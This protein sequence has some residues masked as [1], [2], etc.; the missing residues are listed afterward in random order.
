LRGL[1]VSAYRARFGVDRAWLEARTARQRELGNL[2]FLDDGAR[3]RVVPSRWLWH[4]TIATG[5]L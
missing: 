3:L 5:I 1:D 2:E 4:D